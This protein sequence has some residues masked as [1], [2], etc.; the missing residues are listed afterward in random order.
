MRGLRRV[1]SSDLRGREIPSASYVDALW[2]NSESYVAEAIAG[3]V[4]VADQRVVFDVCRN[5]G[6]VVASLQGSSTQ[7]TLAR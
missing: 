2:E 1:A 6:F 7:K 5:G 3:D 4:G